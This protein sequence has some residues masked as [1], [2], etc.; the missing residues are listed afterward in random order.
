[1]G[2]SMLL[3]QGLR[4]IKCLLLFAILIALQGCTGKTQEDK[5]IQTLD[6]AAAAEKNFNNLQFQ[7][8]ELENKEKQLYDRMIN[9]NMQEYD[10]IVN[11]SNKAIT[12]IQSRNKKLNQEN[13]VMSQS[14]EVFYEIKKPL[15]EMKE[16]RNVQLIYT[17]MLNRYKAHDKLVEYYRESIQEDLVLYDMF[18]QKKLEFEELETQIDQINQLYDKVRTENDRFNKLTDRYNKE[19][20]AIIEQ[21]NK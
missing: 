16:K 21:Y 1:M 7:L 4:L 18:K 17:I 8:M 13:K 2:V 15:G 11:L 10:S 19:R 3:E 9:T 6:K 5:I 14:R 12:N 20:K